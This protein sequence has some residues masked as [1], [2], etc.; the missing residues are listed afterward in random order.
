MG[1]AAAGAMVLQLRPLG[2]LS[3]LVVLTPTEAAL[4][5][6]A[7]YCARPVTL[8]L[9]ESGMVPANLGEL[10]TYE[11]S[12]PWY[13][14]AADLRVW[15]S[16]DPA[17]VLFLGS[18]KDGAARFSVPAGAL[19][20]GESYV[21]ELTPNCTWASAT[22]KV[23]T[24]FSFRVGPASDVPSSL[25]ALSLVRNGSAMVPWGGGAGCW[26]NFK[27]AAAELKLDPD[28]LPE[29]W[30]E[31]LN[32]YQLMVDDEP[33][34][35]TL[36]NGGYGPTQAARGSYGA[37][38]GVFQLWTPCGPL[39]ENHVE[40]ERTPAQATPGKHTVW[41]RARVPGT[42]P[43][44]VE[45]ERVDVVLSCSE[46]KPLPEQSPPASVTPEPEPALVT[47]EPKPESKPESA[48]LNTDQHAVD[49]NDSSDDSEQ[50]TPAQKNDDDGGGCSVRRVAPGNNSTGAALFVA[51]GLTVL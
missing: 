40:H 45:S 48:E 10:T 47:P 3:L 8:L 34:S 39:P 20:V 12:P 49:E 28:A 32:E 36:T 4:A 51:L 44:Y 46:P 30:R 31:L 14:A 26:D 41:V 5:C 13:P 22:E 25:G 19:A 27:A 33:F 23:P 7:P 6:S 43:K 11:A 2:L 21:A 18:A 15:K 1:L 17:T 38:P 42:E 37:R 35:W 24:Q 16:S 9:P 50:I 29:A